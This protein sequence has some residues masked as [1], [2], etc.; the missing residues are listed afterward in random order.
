MFIEILILTGLIIGLIKKESKIIH[1]E[2]KVGKLE[3]NNL[4]LKRV[5]YENGLIPKEY[6]K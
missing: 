1:L 3:S 4:T 2:E 5:M 6:V